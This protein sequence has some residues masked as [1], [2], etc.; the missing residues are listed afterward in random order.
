MY[1]VKIDGEDAY[2]AATEEDLEKWGTAE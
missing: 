1:L 2:E